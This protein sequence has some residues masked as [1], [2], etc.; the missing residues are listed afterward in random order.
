M[1]GLFAD[2]VSGIFFWALTTRLISK[3]FGRWVEPTFKFEDNTARARSSSYK[4]KS[5]AENS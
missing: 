4:K 2:I 1:P 3:Y 5:I